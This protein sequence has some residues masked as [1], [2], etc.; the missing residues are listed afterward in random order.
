LRTGGSNNNNNRSDAAGGELE[1]NRASTNEYQKFIIA[2]LFM[3][4]VTVV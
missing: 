2:W 4:L 3:V 1:I